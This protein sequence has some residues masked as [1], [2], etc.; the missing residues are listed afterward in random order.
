M[1]KTWYI[2]S[3]YLIHCSKQ[4]WWWHVRISRWVVVMNFDLEQVTKNQTLLFPKKNIFSSHSPLAWW[5]LMIHILSTSYSIFV[6]VSCIENSRF[7]SSSYFVQ[8]SHSLPLSLL[9]FA[10]QYGIVVSRSCLWPSYFLL[11]FFFS[12]QVSFLCPVSP[13]AHSLTP[14]LLTFPYTFFSFLSFSHQIFFFNVDLTGEGRSGLLSSSMSPCPG[15]GLA[16]T[17]VQN[18]P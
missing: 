6:K 1:P 11:S 16:P 3:H 7:V 2:W 8:P 12:F 17:P 4:S 18:D 9:S 10:L 13:L 5:A 14:A 15:H